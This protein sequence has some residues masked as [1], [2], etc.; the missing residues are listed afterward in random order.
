VTDEGL[1]LAGVQAE[2]QGHLPRAAQAQAREHAPAVGARLEGLLHGPLHARPGPE[3]SARGSDAGVRVVGPL[4]HDRQRHE[5]AGAIA[6]RLLDL[7]GRQAADVHALH[8]HLV[9]RVAAAVVD[10]QRRA[11]AHDQEQRAHRQQDQAHPRV[12]PAPS[13]ATLG[14]PAGR[15]PGGAASC[16]LT[17]A[18]DL[19]HSGRL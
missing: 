9:G 8:A 17:A 13:P 3:R 12:E 4:D 7:G 15:W 19:A 11:D 14:G 18:R 16:G 5:L 6:H 1:D 2:R 10:G